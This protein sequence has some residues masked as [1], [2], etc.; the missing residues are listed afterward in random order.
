MVTAT[1]IKRRRMNL[2]MQDEVEKEGIVQLVS[3]EEEEVAVF[4]FS[5]F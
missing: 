3:I 2:M 5:I 4:A 1:N